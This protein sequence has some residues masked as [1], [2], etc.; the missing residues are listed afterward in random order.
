VSQETVDIVRNGIA[1]WNRRDARLWLTY[2]APEIEWVPAGPAAVEQAIYRGH[3]EVTRGLAA[4]WDT[5]EVFEFA[6]SEVREIGDAVLWLGNVKMRG[7]TSHVELNQEFALHS[8]LRDGKVLRVQAFLSW[9]EA[10]E[11]AGLEA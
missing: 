1:A 5:W 2:A 6:E 7:G 3:E 10:L 9:R 8:L 4:V 11:A